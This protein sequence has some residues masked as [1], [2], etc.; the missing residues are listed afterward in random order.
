MQKLTRTGV[1][2]AVAMALGAC[3][4]DTATNLHPSDD[5]GEPL[6]VMSRN[7]YL[8]GDI[9]PVMQADFSNPIIT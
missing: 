2:T 6:T 4:D 5:G 8:G 1:V 7:V 9:G 3:S